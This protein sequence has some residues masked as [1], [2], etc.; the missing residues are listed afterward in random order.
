MTIPG[1][2]SKVSTVVGVWVRAC[3]S[4]T[5]QIIARRSCEGQDERVSIEMTVMD[6]RVSWSGRYDSVAI[7]L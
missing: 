6:I 5:V 3:M 4:A 7:G 2:L 1:T